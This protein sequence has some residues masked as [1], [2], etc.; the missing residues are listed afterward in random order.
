MWNDNSIQYNYPYGQQPAW[1]Q[2]TQNMPRMGVYNYGTQP[3]AANLQWIRV[4]GP[5][6]ARDV[7][8]Q[9]GGEAW[10][11]DENRPVFYYK[12]SNEMGQSTTKA[13]RFEEISLDDT[14]NGLD[15][16]RFVTRE[17]IQIISDKLSR[18]E[19]FAADLGGVNE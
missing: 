15:M 11:M 2:P 12:T 9:P 1:R 6:G 16:S 17:E 5:Q 3:P 8:V 4:S 19:K 18:L 7:S 10:I 14:G 13:F